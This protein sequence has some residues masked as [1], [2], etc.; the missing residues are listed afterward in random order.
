MQISC[1]TFHRTSDVVGEV[2]ITILKSSDPFFGG[3][4]KRIKM[5][6]K[7]NDKQ[8]ARTFDTDECGRIKFTN[9]CEKIGIAADS[10]LAK[11]YY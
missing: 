9:A 8:V 2:E 1:K 6:Y 5:G 7:K 11:I 10:I 3:T 4:I